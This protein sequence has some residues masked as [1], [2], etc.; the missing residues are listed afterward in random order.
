MMTK[1][2]PA[3]GTW[4][5]TLQTELLLVHWEHEGADKTRR[6]N[7]ESLG[8]RRRRNKSD[9]TSLIYRMTDI[10]KMKSKNLFLACME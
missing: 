10:L 4:G 2:M 5:Q 3:M 8:R 7:S 9:G 1:A 6:G